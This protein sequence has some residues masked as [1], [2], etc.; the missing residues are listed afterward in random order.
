LPL[1]SFMWCCFCFDSFLPNIMECGFFSW[2]WQHPW[3][4]EVTRNVDVGP[5]I[6]QR[7]CL[8]VNDTL[9]L[10]YFSELR[11]KENLVRYTSFL[12][13]LLVPSQTDTTRRC[14][15]YDVE[16]SVIDRVKLTGT[17]Q[18]GALEMDMNGTLAVLPRERITAWS[19]EQPALYYVSFFKNCC[20]H[21]IPL[22][23]YISLLNMSR[24][25]GWAGKGLCSWS[26]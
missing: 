17:V 19:P 24:G 7:R 11:P 14:T 1:F 18:E 3:S 8:Y 13:I 10:P 2:F 25:A 26:R 22:Y 12:R 4:S 6:F 5:L 16:D 15:L 23:I 21:R 20:L 9:A